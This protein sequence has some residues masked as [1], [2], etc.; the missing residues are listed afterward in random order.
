MEM[1]GAIGAS[2]L[3]PGIV[4]AAFGGH[5]LRKARASR[6]SAAFGPRSVGLALR[7]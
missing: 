5:A 2:M 7:F 6:F 4:L 1:V 3:I